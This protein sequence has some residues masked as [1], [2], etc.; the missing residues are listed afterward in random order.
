M[1]W[2]MTQLITF[3]RNKY[4]MQLLWTYQLQL[5]TSTTQ[6]QHKYNTSTLVF[7]AVHQLIQSHDAK[8][9]KSTISLSFSLA[10]SIYY[11]SIYISIYLLIYLS[12]NLSSIYLSTRVNAVISNSIRKYLAKSKQYI[13]TTRKV[14]WHAT[15]IHEGGFMSDVELLNGK[16]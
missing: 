16:H 12:I 11:Q 2:F 8:V 15:M 14:V 6:V 1:A 3:K 4:N 5:A 9:T 7:N 10:L 13:I